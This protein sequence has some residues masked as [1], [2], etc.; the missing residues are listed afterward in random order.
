MTDACTLGYRWCLLLKGDD[1]GGMPCAVFDVDSTL[2][3]GKGGK[4]TIPIHQV[5]Q[6]YVSLMQRGISVFIV[7]ARA[8]E[9]RQYTID[10]LRSIGIDS[11]E[12]L[13]MHPHPCTSHREAALQKK[14]AREKIEARGYT[15]LL[16]AGDSWSDHF[17][18]DE[19]EVRRRTSA[20]E[21]FTYVDRDNVFHIKL[22]TR[23]RL[24]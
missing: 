13:Y 12:H 21:I 24:D 17:R 9:G 1:E 22:P 15:I 18:K 23:R 7:T 16:N 8:E 11:C 19:L 5:C 14:K 10:Q 4:D 20:E 6:L 2:L 3:F